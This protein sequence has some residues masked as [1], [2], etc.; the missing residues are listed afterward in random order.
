[1][2]LQVGE[3]RSSL[4][5]RRETKEKIFQTLRADII[6]QKLKPGQ[7]VREED[8]AN[9]FGVS[10]TP[11][12]EMLL[13]LEYEDLVKLVPNRGVFVSELMSKDIEEVIE[14]RLT[15]ETTAAR[16]AASKLTEQHISELN[17]ISEELDV[18]V[19]LQDSI[20]SFGADSRLHNLI[21]EAAGNHRAHKIIN[22]LMGQIHRI[23]FI[24]GHKPGRI[25]TTTSEQK[26]IIRALLN[27]DPA[28][29]EEAM[30]IHL[31]N[32]K[33]LLLP[34]SEMERKFEE[35]VRNSVPI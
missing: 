2:N 28:K 9:R 34:S 26:E 32:T 29:A 33:E 21:L 30:R 8:L 14:I 3:Y 20:L 35:F 7:A 27:K 6:S 13:R 12:R 19:E 15:L 24:S 25:N 17:N 10:R 23:R 18:A 11:I 4:S 5:T 1:M 16:M 22:N 31:L